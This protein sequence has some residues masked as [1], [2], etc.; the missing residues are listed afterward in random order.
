MPSSL[1]KNILRANAL[2]ILVKRDQGVIQ[3]LFNR[4]AD[5][6]GCCVRA[7]GD[8]PAGVRLQTRLIQ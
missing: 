1:S 2:A 3:C 7:L 6:H 4:N 8:Q 5:V